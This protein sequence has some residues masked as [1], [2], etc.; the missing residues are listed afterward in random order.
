M[1]PVSNTSARRGTG[2]E[3][4]AKT[5]SPQCH[6]FVT[7]LFGAEKCAKGLEKRGRLHGFGLSEPSPPKSEI[8]PR[9][10]P[11]LFCIIEG[12]FPSIHWKRGP[13]RP[14]GAQDCPVNPVLGAGLPQSILSG[15]QDCF[16]QSCRHSRIAPVHYQ[17][18][19]LGAVLARTQPCDR[20]GP[21]VEL[22]GLMLR[23]KGRPLAKSASRSSEWKARSCPRLLVP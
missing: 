20:A 2:E 19:W 15:A 14:P 7:A 12:Y 23:R 3:S 5:V 6:R 1:S 22:P 16:T 13:T 21:A 11:K 9:S 10:T 8:R 4:N 18:L 17:Q